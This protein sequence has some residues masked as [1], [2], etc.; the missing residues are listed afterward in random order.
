MSATRTSRHKEQTGTSKGHLYI[1]SYS[2]ITTSISSSGGDSVSER[3][4][5][6]YHVKL[7]KKLNVTILRPYLNEYHLITADFHEELTLQA[8]HA[9]K[10][11]RLVA[12]L[13]RSGTDFLERFIQC[14]RESVE[15][16]GT[17][18]GEIANALE[19]LKL[20][21]LETSGKSV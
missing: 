20:Q 9:A 14:L 8:T 3:V 17:Y 15:E 2:S 6:N 10:V 4:L 19:E 5:R 18:H 13:P 16:T 7:K 11:D 12:E 21:E 1:A